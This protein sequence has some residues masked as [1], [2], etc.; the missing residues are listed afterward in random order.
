MKAAKKTSTSA[1][2]T[3]ELDDETFMSTEQL[4]GYMSALVAANACKEVD[5]MDRAIERRKNN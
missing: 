5:L 3:R 2:A 4:R 1:N